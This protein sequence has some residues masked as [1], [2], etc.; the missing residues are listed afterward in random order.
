MGERP[1]PVQGL[2]RNLSDAK[3][4]REFAMEFQNDLK[5]IEDEEYAN[6]KHTGRWTPEDAK[7][8]SNRRARL[9]ELWEEAEKLSRDA[10]FDYIDRYGKRILFK[11]E[12]IVAHVV[13]LNR[14][15]KADDYNEVGGWKKEYGGRDKK[16]KR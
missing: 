5:E 6:Y 14:L 13:R 15:T 16:H 7:I 3:L 4:A 8:W 11:K 10:G 2:I 9:D 1:P 12:S